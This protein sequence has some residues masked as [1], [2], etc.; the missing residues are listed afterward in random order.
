[1]A[2]VQIPVE[3][4]FLR[5]PT[6]WEVGTEFPMPTGLKPGA[7]PEDV[8]LELE[9]T[10]IPTI[11][12]GSASYVDGWKLRDRFLKLNQT[13]DEALGFLYDI[14]L[15]ST[16]EG[17]DTPI[18]ISDETHK[19]SDRALTNL[20]LSKR[21]MSSVSGLFAGR[22]LSETAMPTWA[23]VLWSFQDACRTY[24]VKPKLWEK[25]LEQ[26]YGLPSGDERQ[27][28]WKAFLKRRTELPLRV[29]WQNGQPIGVI[30]VISGEQL[31]I[32]TT[33]IDLIRGAKFKLCERPDCRTPF[34][35]LSGHDKKYCEH[36]CA[37]IE[38]VRRTRAEKKR[39]QKDS[40]HDTKKRTR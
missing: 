13:Q 10:L 17:I 26:P 37:H 25:F 32:A 2:Q 7:K 22:Y 34:P 9:P 23:S 24:L 21:P 39:Q 1:M 31:L 27:A 11:L 28:S 6:S 8:K 36:Y 4:R 33:Q 38:S 35:I 19:L 40:H 29:E 12:K 15:W 3:V 5:I 18:D 30:E 14:G 16:T 20:V